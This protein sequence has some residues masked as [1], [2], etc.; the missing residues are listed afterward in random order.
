MKF[1]RT[2]IAKISGLNPDRLQFYILK[3]VFAN[4]EFQ[5]RGKATLFNEQHL[6]EVFI[7]KRLD[8]MGVTLSYIKKVLDKLRKNF[9]YNIYYAR[10]NP[11]EK[12]SPPVYKTWFS[13]QGEGVSTETLINPK[14]YLIIYDEVSMITTLKV[15][16]EHDDTSML[17]HKMFMKEHKTAITIDI[18]DAFLTLSKL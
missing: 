3:N 18:T 6:V 4:L 2:E 8:S 14:I 9:H 16:E 10:S 13:T 11:Q 12:D 7:I 1:K 17:L 5:G 15:K